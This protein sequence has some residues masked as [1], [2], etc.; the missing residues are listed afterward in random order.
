[1]SKTEIREWMIESAYG[2]AAMLPADPGEAYLVLSM[3]HRM[4][5]EINKRLLPKRR[6]HKRR[7]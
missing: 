1:M 2:I 5:E 3:V 6:R 7:K 4:I